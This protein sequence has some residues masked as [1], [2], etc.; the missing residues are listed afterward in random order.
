MRSGPSPFPSSFRADLHSHTT[1]SDGTLSPAE[2]VALAVKVGLQGLSITDHDTVDAYE[3]AQ[4]EADRLGL[5]LLPGIEFSSRDDREAV[6]VLGYGFDLDNASLHALCER[7]VVERLERNAQILKRL[8]ELGMPVT[9]EEVQEV[10]GIAGKRIFGRPHIAQVMRQKGYVASVREAFEKWLAEGQPGYARGRDAT[11]QEV[12]DV[13]HQANG[14]AVIAHPHFFKY[15][16]TAQRLLTLNFDGIECYYS[17]T[18]S[19]L[20]QP[21]IDRAKARGWLVTGGSD[22]HGENKPQVTLGCSWVDGPTFQAL[23]SRVNS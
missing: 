17:L 12:I 7:R 9:Q 14:K 2:L 11:V 22:F 20:E 4:A 15:S 23:Q 10:A 8:D 6:H 5:H 18:S 16:S 21:W 1:C 19:A 13:I 3:T